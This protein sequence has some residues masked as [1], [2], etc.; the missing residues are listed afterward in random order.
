M[1]EILQQ[2]FHSEEKN[3]WER[4]KIIMKEKKF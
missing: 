4:I 1:K 3:P 2:S